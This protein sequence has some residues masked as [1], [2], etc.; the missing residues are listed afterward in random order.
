MARSVD[1]RSNTEEPQLDMR[2]ALDHCAGTETNMVCYLGNLDVCRYKTQT[3]GHDP[4][5]GT[6]QELE[7]HDFVIYR[8]ARHQPRA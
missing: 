2:L 4:N 5:D 8:S 7:T 6:L 1:G 3:H